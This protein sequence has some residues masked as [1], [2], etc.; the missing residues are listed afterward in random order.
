VLQALALEG[1]L[2]TLYH[3]RLNHVAAKAFFRGRSAA[4]PFS[5]FGPALEVGRRNSVLAR[6]Q[7]MR[8]GLSDAE[9]HALVEETCDLRRAQCAAW[10][11][12]WLVALPESQAAAR[13]SRSLGVDRRWFG[14]GPISAQTLLD[15]L[16]LRVG[17]FGEETAPDPRRAVYATDLYEEFF[18]HG[19]G[20]RPQRVLQV[21]SRC[22]DGVEEPGTCRKAQA[23]FRAMA[24]LGNARRDLGG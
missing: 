7:A 24:G 15:L 22:E 16:D 9:W 20:L 4:L 13:V 2:H 11:S 5:G 8:R 21:W 18:T 3:P 6:W 12:E 23:E 17:S 1:P 10:L 19:T 14:E